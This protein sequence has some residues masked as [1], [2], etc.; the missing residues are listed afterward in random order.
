MNR[1]WLEVSAPGFSA[2]QVLITLMILGTLSAIGV[3]I[4]SNTLAYF[5]VSGDARGLSNATQVAKMRAAADFTKARIYIDLAAKTYRLEIWQKTAPVGWT[6]EGNSSMR[7][8]KVS[9]SFG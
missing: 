2:V 8:S 1:Q 4:T 7:S 6:M 9:F 5:R 3:P